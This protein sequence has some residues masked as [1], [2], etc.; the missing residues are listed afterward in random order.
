MIYGAA[1]GF[2]LIYRLALWGNCVVCVAA[3]AV[4]ANVVVAFAGSSPPAGDYFFYAY[5][6]IRLKVNCCHQAPSPRASRASR[7]ASKTRSP[8]PA[9]LV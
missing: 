3:V 8:G 9:W 4:L 6:C 2:S 7:R 5:F 1:F